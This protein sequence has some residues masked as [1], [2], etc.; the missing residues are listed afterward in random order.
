[1]PTDSAPVVLHG[2]NISYFTGKMENYFRVRSIPYQLQSPTYPAHRDRMVKKVGV[3]QMPAVELPDGRW[4]T[5]ST[6]MIQWFEKEVP[7]SGVIPDDPVLRFVSLL[8][9]DWADEW[10]W[11]PAMHYRWHY[12]EGARFASFH[13]ATEVLGGLPLPVWAKRRMMVHRQRSG[14]TEGDGIRPES[15]AGVEAGVMRLLGQ[16]EGIFSHRPFLLGDRPSLADIGFSGPFFRHFALDP[17][18]LEILRQKAPSVLEWVARLWNTRL[19]SCSGQWNTQLPDDIGPL[20][21]DIGRAYLP[22]LCANAEA[23]AADKQRF[24]IEL[25]GVPYQGARTSRYRVWCL[26]QLR[27]HYRKLDEAD[28]STLKVL[29]EQHGCWEPLWRLATLPLSPA[30]ENQLPFR[31]DAKMLAVNE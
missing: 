7:G 5:D 6:V 24:D 12:P 13:L 29:L 16:L 1:M 26:A 17:V 4:M 19:E 8:L 14:Y 15:V 23:V 2:S 27:E 30:Q 10:W 22:Y 21:S 31:A 11:R 25:G 9:E 3:H 20:L 18:P 28:Q